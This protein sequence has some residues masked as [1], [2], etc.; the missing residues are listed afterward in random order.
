MARV[1]ISEG[2]RANLVAELEAAG[3]IRSGR[4]RD[5]FLAVPRELFVPLHVARHGL[6]AVYRNE[7]IVTK[8][9][10]HG[11]P[12][13]S[14]SE[15]QVMAAMLEQLDVREGMRVLEVGAGTGY[16]AALLE[17]LVG[18]RGRVVAVDVEPDAATAA[19][20]ALRAGGYRA[21]V[22]HRDGRQGYARSA[23]YD[24]IVVT[25]SSA[26]VPPALFEQ[27]AEGGLLELPLR[28]A[29]TGAQAIVTL[30]RAGSTLRSVGVVPGQFM[31]LRGRG[32]VE[33]PEVS[34]VANEG[35][36]GR[37]MRILT[38]VAG[39]GVEALGPEGR[40]RLLAVALG[41]PRATRLGGRFP[42]WSLGLYLSLE[43]PRRRLV[44]R[45]TDLGVGVAGRSGRS[46]ALVEG[47]WQGG[48]RAGVL[49]MLAYGEGEAEERLRRVLDRWKARGRPG[50]E[51]LDVRVD[52]GG[53]E[54]VL[55][56]RWR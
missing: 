29:P 43:L 11:R 27:L 16:N 33:Q 36:A 25:A 15:P 24:R 53:G 4:V 51:R 9:D 31:P 6:Q 2:L 34:L 30:R 46:L 44:V 54:P 7:V 12:L 39:P 56:H 23:P 5:A 18:P 37:A 42:A 49:R 14:S 8:T 13:S 21:R 26:G 47:R 41:E 28:V 38:H 55:T 3:A 10:R 40:R 32:L 35:A 52:L 1:T 20:A 19:G 17:T 22:L 48:E 45:Y 50:Q